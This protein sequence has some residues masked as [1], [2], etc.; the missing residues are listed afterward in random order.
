MTSSLMSPPSLSVDSHSAT[1]GSRGDLCFCTEQHSTDPSPADHRMLCQLSSVRC[2]VGHT[3]R[4]THISKGHMV[5]ESTHC[6]QLLFD[7]TNRE[8]VGHGR[9]R[10]A[11]RSVRLSEI[12]ISE[13]GRAS[14]LP[15]CELSGPSSGEG[16]EGKDSIIHRTSCPISLQ[17]IMMSDLGAAFQIFIQLGFCAFGVSAGTYV[18][19]I[20]HDYS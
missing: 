12:I 6:H 16:F 9:S 20:N 2:Q 17:V 7:D 4:H 18:F 3:H 10:G 5:F 1:P 11:V 14:V 13:P 19:V 15:L 8:Q